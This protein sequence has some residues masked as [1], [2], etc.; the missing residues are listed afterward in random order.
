MTQHQET[1]AKYVEMK[2]KNVSIFHK[3]LGRC[4]WLDYY[5]NRRDFFFFGF[6]LFGFL[7]FGGIWL[8][9]WAIAMLVMYC[10]SCNSCDRR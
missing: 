2:Q 7:L 4:R 10:F 9:R 1:H 8:A 6:R 5:R 3:E